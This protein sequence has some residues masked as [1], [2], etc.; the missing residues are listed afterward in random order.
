MT[1]F[2]SS[3]SATFAAGAGGGSSRLQQSRSLKEQP[4]LLQL[5]SDLHVSRLSL[6]QASILAT[7][8]RLDLDPGPDPRGRTASNLRMQRTEAELLDV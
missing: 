1:V 4:G 8:K 6:H 7:A 2:A 3:S 5:C